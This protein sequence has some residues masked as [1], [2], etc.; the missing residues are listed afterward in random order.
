MRD[1]GGVI[2]DAVFDGAYFDANDDLRLCTP[3]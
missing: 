2:H 3:F 1:G